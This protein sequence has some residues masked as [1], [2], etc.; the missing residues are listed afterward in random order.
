M[1]EWYL[2]AKHNDNPLTTTC[3]GPFKTALMADKYY[4]E[5]KDSVYDSTL[6]SVNPSK[7]SILKYKYDTQV[8]D[9]FA[10]KKVEMPF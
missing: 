8:W 6:L 5:N 1:E 4:H 9:K 3:A 2:C 7:T 10:I